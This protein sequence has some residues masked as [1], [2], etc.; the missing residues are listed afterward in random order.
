MDIYNAVKLVIRYFWLLAV[1]PL[2]AGVLMFMLLRSQSQEF[3]S[4]A[5]IYTG[6]TSGH[7]IE[8]Q[9]R[10]RV[11]YFATTVA[12]DNMLNILKSKKVLEE[13]GLRLFVQNIML[14]EPNHSYLSHDNFHELKDLVPD[15]VKAL[16]VRNNFEETLRRCKAY[17]DTDD[18]NF[19]YGLVNLKH[20]HYSVEALSKVTA[21]R[22]QGSDLLEISFRSDDPGIAYQTLII[23]ID[24]FFNTHSSLKMAQ[25]STVV[26]YFERQLATAWDK[27]VA[28]ENRLLEFNKANRIINYHEQTKYV[29]SQKESFELTVQQTQMEQGAAVSM[30]EK[31]EAEIAS[32]HNINMKTQSIMGLRNELVSINEQ[33][34]HMGAFNP[35][36]VFEEHARQLQQ[37]KTE[38]ETSIQ[39]TV[40]DMFMLERS[41]DGIEREDIL[42]RWFDNVLSL[43]A[44]NARLAV[45]ESKRVEFDNLYMFFAPLGATINRIERAIGVHE[46]EYLSIL[47]NL[48]LA[49][50]KQQNLELSASMDLLDQPFFPIQ[51]QPGRKKLFILVIM[52]FSGFF[53]VASIFIM[54]LLDRRVK[55]VKR[56]AAATNTSLLGAV[57]D[58][59]RRHGIDIPL[60]AKRASCDLAGNVM[61]ILSD[62]DKN[63]NIDNNNIKIIQ[64][65]SHWTREGKSFVA[66]KLQE[67]LAD[68]GFSVVVVQV[69]SQNPAAGNPTA[70]LAVSREHYRTLK[71]FSETARESTRF[72]WTEADII[73]FEIPALS[74]F[75]I[76]QDLCKQA[77]INVLLVNASRTWSSADNHYLKK[78]KDASPDNLYALIN[79]IS[80]DHIE[81]YIG[82]IPKKR[83]LLRRIIKNRLFKRYIGFHS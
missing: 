22:V 17:K 13:V 16:V 25:T 62:Q 5:T 34:E 51:A 12:F 11:D 10:D 26:D 74:F 19:L 61:Q 65:F 70:A 28:E 56:L 58:E 39:Q 77:N 76:N 55:S 48:G 49:K 67:E 79:Q 71:H 60:L 37:R 1:V 7:S 59:K 54:E 27:L 18:E 24:V 68:L 9:G 73:I 31:L 41:I 40:N 43:E 72:P 82:D 66:A 32:R 23:L 57:L 47:H 38:I 6:I 35:E 78:L 75:M 21:R 29:A 69:E 8:S 45:L 53:V 44:A 36:G 83:S 63:N 50:L 64:L 3:V 14:D 81:A 30:L 15:E 20:R 52:V 46:R 42:D 33:L 80:P 4:K 2:S